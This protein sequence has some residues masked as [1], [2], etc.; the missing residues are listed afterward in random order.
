[1]KDIKVSYGNSSTG[2]NP[3]S[4]AKFATFEAFEKDS[5][6]R[7]TYVT[8]PDVRAQMLKDVYAQATSGRTKEVVK[9]DK[10]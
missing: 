5:E 6:H 9:G 1:M 10:K 7:L 3:N 2:F 4:V 8:E